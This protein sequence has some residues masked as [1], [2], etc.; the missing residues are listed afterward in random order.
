MP[1]KNSL[2]INAPRQEIELP[3]STL[4]QYMPTNGNRLSV[5]PDE[6]TATLGY[7]SGIISLLA[8]SI[9]SLA[10]LSS[11]SSK[12]NKNWS[13]LVGARVYRT[14]HTQQG[15]IMGT[16]IKKTIYELLHVFLS[17]DK[18]LNVSLFKI[19]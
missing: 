15:C 13:S 11:R 19:M 2:F 4:R 18:W 10:T 12:E 6:R 3:F 14:L 17:K 8:T 16:Y 5:M 7:P 1:H 9:R